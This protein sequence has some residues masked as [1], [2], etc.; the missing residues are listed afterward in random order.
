MS[1]KSH[2]RF[3]TIVQYTGIYDMFVFLKNTKLSY[4]R[5]SAQCGWCGLQIQQ[6]H[7][8]ASNQKMPPKTTQIHPVL[9]QMIYRRTP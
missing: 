5:D 7:S 2:Q 3:L 1:H 4:C 9:R 8:S 6:S